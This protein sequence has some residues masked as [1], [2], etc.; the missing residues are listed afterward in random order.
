[1]FFFHKLSNIFMNS[2]RHEN[3]KNENTEKWCDWLIN[4]IKK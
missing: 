3:D 1:M 2:L 4:Y